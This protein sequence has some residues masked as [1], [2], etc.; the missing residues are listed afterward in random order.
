MY[1]II[2]VLINSNNVQDNTGADYLVLSISCFPLT[3][4]TSTSMTKLHL[5][6]ERERERREGEERE[7]IIKSYRKL[8]SSTSE[9]N[10]LAQV[11]I[12]QAM[13]G[14]NNLPDFTFLHISYSS[15]PPT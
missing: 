11:P 5:K 7:R 10:I 1:K 9:V 8:N 14:L 3:T 12:H 2:Q 13:T 6:R 4:S 15:T